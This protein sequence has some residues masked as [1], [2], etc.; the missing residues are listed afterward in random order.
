MFADGTQ[1]KRFPKLFGVSLF[2]FIAVKFIFLG[3]DSYFADDVQA[4]T[5]FPA[6]SQVFDRQGT[7]LYEF[8]GDIRRIPVGTEEIPDYLRQAT[9]F[10]EDE[11]F[12]SHAGFD[13]I[14]I[15]RALWNNIADKKGERQGASTLGQQLAKNTI[16]GRSQGYVDKAKEILLSIALDG[17]MSKDDILHLYLNTIPYGSNVY[18]VETASRLYFRKH[19]HELTLAQAATLAAL[20]K[21]PSFLS[22]Y[23]GDVEALAARRDMILGKM[24]DAQQITDQEYATAL[25][26]PMDFA[27]NE[28]P[29]IAPHFVMEVR[30]QLE[31]T[32]GKQALEEEGLSIVTTLD[33]SV[34][35]QTEEAVK[36]KEATL[37]Y[38]KADNVGA[39]V[40]DPRTGDVLA[41]VGNRDYFDQEHA[42]NFNMAMALRQPGSTFKPL[43][44]ATLLD[45][46]A[47]T[48]ATVLYDTQQNFG[49]VLE[50][51]IPRNYDGKFRG[52]VTVR[53]ALAQSLNIP[54][55]RTLLM[56]GIDPVI[57]TAEDMGLTTLQARER[58][59]PSLVLG[60]AEVRLL[61]L[62]GA[63]G[64]F[65]N[66]GE[67]VPSRM[68]LA[69]TQN[70]HPYWTP[71]TAPAQQAVKPET[72]FQIT[73]I[74]SDRWARAPIFGPGGSLYI[75]DRQVAVKTGT[76][77]GYRDAWTIGYTPSVVVGVWVGNEDNR[78]LREGGSGAMAAAPVWRAIIDSYLADKPVE[79]F[80]MPQDLKLVYIPTVVG[81]RK[82]YVASWQWPPSGK[83]LVK[84][85]TY[86]QPASI[87]LP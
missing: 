80:E 37:D 63:Y 17:Q 77:Q 8:V 3:I 55:V 76:T 32:I 44:Y 25:S 28:M 1:Q 85:I 57:D 14:G 31:E 10:A 20:P 61:E 15:V 69:V 83:F 4:V 54:A 79:T 29:I 66:N 59:G 2:L 65:A 42:G 67:F 51:Y 36:S 60:G 50:P 24:H 6:S 45:D 56:A 5:H 35:A 7:L 40:I 52:A 82:E 48:P 41:M 49:T 46:K 22:P 19:V 78:P 27:P 43:A 26:E 62:A 73:S 47:I 70:D 18:G 38:N 84:T 53:D 21:H 39:V 71:E 58:F 81:V 74:L 13:P 68:V 11:R 23:G 86:K 64:A 9:L 12:F 75:K 72:A 30:H 33:A 87:S 34:Q 16:L